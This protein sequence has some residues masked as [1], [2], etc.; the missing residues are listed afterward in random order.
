LDENCELGQSV[1]SSNIKRRF[2][3]PSVA[4]INACGTAKP[5]ALA[6]VRQLNSQGV[7]AVIATKTLVDGRMAGLFLS[8]LFA[9]LRV[10]ET[11][12]S[13]SLAR[14]KFDAVKKLSETVIPNSRKRELYGSKA[15]NYS[16]LGNGNVRVCVTGGQARPT[17]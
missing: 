8:N 10:N 6:F 11:D 15:Y 9:A 5:G 12:A 13:Y 16:L 2:D 3:A 1:H 7:G 4:I 14:A 17:Q